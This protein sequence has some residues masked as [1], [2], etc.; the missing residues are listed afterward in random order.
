[1]ITRTLRLSP[2]HPTGRLVF[3]SLALATLSA[4]A[5]AQFAFSEQIGASGMANLRGTARPGAR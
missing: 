3:S 5:S 4:S 2:A 1:M